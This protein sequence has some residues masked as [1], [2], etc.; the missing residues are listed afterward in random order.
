MDIEGFTRQ[1]L[2]GNEEKITQKRLLDKI[3]EYKNISP[4][5][6]GEM[7]WAVIDEVKS[8]LKIKDHPDKDL[9]ELIGYPSAGV[10][11]GEMGV[12]SRGEGDFF[13]HRR[14]ADIVKSTHTNAFINPTAQDDGGV[15]RS[16][17]DG[18][19]IYITT[20]VDGIHSRLSEYPFLGGFHVA[21]A[22]MRDV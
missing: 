8:T 6:A 3:L 12:G 22:A 7:A 18:E 14:I 11:M 17:L 19:E 4:E 21:R 15:V 13:V 10:A 1:A 20:A 2:E 5:L 9:Q 16:T